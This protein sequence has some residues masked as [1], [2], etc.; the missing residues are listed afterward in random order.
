M[1]IA[2]RYFCLQRYKT[3]NNKTTLYGHLDLTKY[4]HSLY[5]LC[6]LYVIYTMHTLRHKHCVYA[7]VRTVLVELTVNTFPLSS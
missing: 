1:S 2:S 5:S 7:C 3:F 4:T 6:R